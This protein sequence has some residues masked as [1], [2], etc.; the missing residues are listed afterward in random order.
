MHDYDLLKWIWFS[1]SSVPGSK[2]AGMLLA[3]FGSAEEVYHYDFD[4]ND[5]FDAVLSKN[6]KSLLVN[7]SLTE[8]QQILEYCDENDIFIIPYCDS[9]YPK[10]LKMIQDPP[11]LLY[12]KGKEVDFNKGVYIASVGTRK[13][14]DYGVKSAN[15]ICEGL[16]RAGITVVSGMADGID[17]YSH[18]A[19]LNGDGMTVAVL[20]CGVDIIYPKC[21]EPLYHNLRK[22]GLIISEYPPLSG[23]SKTTFPE[24]NRIIS[25]ICDG[26]LVIEAPAQSGALITANRALSQGRSLYAV[27]GNIDASAS[28]GTNMLIQQGAKMVTGPIDIIAEYQLVHPDTVNVLPAVKHSRGK[29]FFTKKKKE[30][31]NDVKKNENIPRIMSENERKIYNALSSI[32]KSAEEISEETGIPLTNTLTQLTLFSMN[33]I[34]KELPGDLF[35]RTNLKG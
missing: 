7:K 1:I 27:P 11:A 29:T 13:S 34:A 14:T 9:R 35:V 12:C 18:I 33:A 6:A 2:T 26:V 20:G 30:T 24:R 17:K 15:Y 25:G 32:P 10:K 8:A 16:A 5:D 28:V 21:N 23:V 3:S 19:A 31:K 4:A 22:N